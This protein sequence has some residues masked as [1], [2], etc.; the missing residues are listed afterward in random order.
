VALERPFVLSVLFALSPVTACHEPAPPSAV[1]APPAKQEQRACS[2]ESRQAQACTMIYAPV[3][4][5]VDT[6]IRC[7]TAPCPST[8]LVKFSYACVACKDRSTIGYY[9]GECVTSAR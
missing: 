6:G 3:C 5:V 2:P 8:K 4:A 9:A 7:I 1:A